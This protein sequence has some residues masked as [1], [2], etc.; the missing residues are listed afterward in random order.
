[1]KLLFE[2]IWSWPV[3]LLSC[4]VLAGVVLAAYPRRVRHLTGWLP[5]ILLALRIGLV[6]IL[7]FWMLRP[8][9]ILESRDRSTAVLYVINDVSR[10]MLTP[11]APGGITRFAAQ[12][13]LLVEAREYLDELDDSVEVRFRSFAES[14]VAADAT[15]DQPDGEQTSISNCLEQLIQEAGSGKVAG[16]LLLSDGRQ[17]TSGSA[18][19]DPLPFAR[20]LGRQQSAIYSVAFGSPELSSTSLDVAVSELDVARDAFVRNVLPVRVRIRALGAAGSG[21]RVRVLL[22]QQPQQNERSGEMASVALM[23]HKPDSDLSDEFVELQF[24]PQMPGEFKVAVEAEPLPG[25]VRPT[26]NRVETIIRVR[27]GGIRVAYFDT[28]RQE[29]HWLN[30]ITVSSRIQLDFQP[31]LSGQF[32]DRTRFDESW[33]V[34]GNIDAF[35]IG[36]VP[37]DVFGRERLEAIRRCCTQGAGLMMIGGV[38]NYGA[39]DYH[40]H[41]LGQ[42]LPVDVAATVDQ[43]TD[44]VPMRPT[45]TGLL[46]SVMQIAPPDINRRRWE[47]LPPL[48]GAT[49]LRLK[50]GLIAQVLAKSPNG[51]PLLVGHEIGDSRI[52]AFAGDT[53][54]QWFVQR[55]RESGADVFRRFWR[56]VVFWLTKQEQD[57]DAPVWATVE[58]RDLLPGQVAE[59]RYGA[60]DAEGKPIPDATYDVQ[61][62]RPDDTTESVAASNDAG[63]GASRYAETG[64]PGDYW[65]RVTAARDG[66]T[67]GLA[68]T[69][70]LVNQ[71]D[72][73][74]DNPSANPD[75]MRELAHVSGGDILSPDELLERLREWAA[76]GLPSLELKRTARRNLWDNWFTLLVFA[77]MLTGEWALRKKS[78]LV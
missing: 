1:M 53:T 7:L 42:L 59:L 31:V 44:P 23:V 40:R 41:Q 48:A 5:Q 14:L 60:R 39:G 13:Q 27:K 64:L 52:L 28:L 51:T 3:V 32:A 20:L 17:A 70:F 54:W 12:Q 50:E 76:D 16:I 8:S 9:V 56:Q 4:A 10:S 36:D 22:E 19:Q 26:N 2:P 71:R 55:E 63:Q 11:D 75:L 66:Q 15:A 57:S 25:E 18:D 47:E 24:V 72:P 49:L 29:Q 74:L 61:I 35:I 78:G 21:I 73:E 30:S 68:I 43:L 46:H 62:T 77:G 67:L 58:P 38:Q 45:K 65:I 33:F 69:R 37:A 6:L 34:P